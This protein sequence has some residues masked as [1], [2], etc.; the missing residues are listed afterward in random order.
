MMYEFI[1]IAGCMTLVALL[2][3]VVPL[4]RRGQGSQAPEPETVSV[5]LYRQRLLE[6][7][8]DRINGIVPAND[9]EAARSELDRQLLDDTGDAGHKPVSRASKPGRLAIAFIVLIL[10]L[11]GYALYSEVGGMPWRAAQKNV[12]TTDVTPANIHQ[13]M[14]RLAAHL[15]KHPDDG[16]GW[17]MLGRS[18]LLT[19]NPKGAKD[20]LHHARELLGDTPETLTDY[21][22]ALAMSG[23]QPTFEGEP[24]ELLKKALALDS[25][26]PK[27]LWLSGYAA[28]RAGNEREAI[29]DWQRLIQEE[30][31][32]SHAAKVLNNA[33]EQARKRLSGKEKSS[34][35]AN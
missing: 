33:I 23:K 1:A 6:L 22:E 11:F 10:P 31:P 26:Y 21:A 15:Q 8:Q 27:A 32:G 5:S 13:M 29:T 34:S 17:L 9:F 25:H 20:A 19:G 12:Q 16:E 28:A 18:Y 14:R 24:S 7:E 35:G 2:F 3:I 4:W 30:K